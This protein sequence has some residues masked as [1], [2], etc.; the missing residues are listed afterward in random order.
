MKP[1]E[2]ETLFRWDGK[3]TCLHSEL[4]LKGSHGLGDPL[5]IFDGKSWHT[6][7][8]KSKKGLC[9]MRGLDLF[10][11]QER[12]NVY[13]SKFRNHMQELKGIQINHID[14]EVLKNLINLLAKLLQYYGMTEFFYTDLA[15][16]ELEN[17]PLL[18]KNIEDLNRLKTEGRETLNYVV[19]ENGLLPRIL[20]TISKRFLE[21][22]DDAFYLY[23]DELIKLF[24]GNLVDKKIIEERKRCY[25]IAKNDEEIIRFDRDVT[26]ELVHVFTGIKSNLIRGSVANKG[27]AKGRVVIAPMLISRDGVN[28]IIN[29]MKKGD[30]LV[31]QS[32]TP[33]LM[34]LVEKAAAIVTDQGGMLSHAA[35]ISREFGIPC[36]VGTGDATRIL[37]DGDIVE[38]DVEKGVVRKV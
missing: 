23:S 12:Y 8:K 33:E 20:S 1:E 7:L 21:D 29:K 19:F 5:I 28:A 26:K 16:K 9:L 18:K 36:I 17:D 31:A 34:G 14:Q 2:Y 37:K 32:T 30:I 38:V 10:K 22:Y 11:S 25:A 27:K 24:D 15:Y 6:F 35:I 4:F 3:I 13:S